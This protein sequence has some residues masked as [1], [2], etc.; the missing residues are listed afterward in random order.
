MDRRSLLLSGLA[1]AAAVAAAPHALA[2][3]A[4]PGAK[5]AETTSKCIA[6]GLACLAHCQRE[7]AAG[8]KSM[9]E[10]EAS[11][12]DMLAACEAL[13]KIA[14][15]GSKHLKTFAKACADVCADC[16][17]TCE[18]HAKHMAECKACMDACNDCKKACDA[19]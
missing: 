3:G 17:K 7:L 13:Q 18:P 11:V 8:N 16:A 6:V 19:A 9:A 12:S 10:C 15:R 2:E 5:I 14:T 1:T 4:S